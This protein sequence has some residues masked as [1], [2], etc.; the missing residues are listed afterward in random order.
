MIIRYKN[1]RGAVTVEAIISLTTFMFAIVTVFT[2]VNICIVQSQISYALNVTAK[3]ISQYSY[4][5]S[6]SG[7][8]DSFKSVHENGE[9][10]TKDIDVF[11]SDITAAYE[12]MEQL[13]REA[14]NAKDAGNV[15]DIKSAWNNFEKNFNDLQAN[16][17][18]IKEDISNI[19]DDPKKIIFGIAKLG[20]VKG[21]DILIS[22]CIAQ[23]LIKGMIKKNLMDE[24]NG[25][26]EVYLKNL[27]VIPDGKGSYF[28]GLDFKGS[29]IFPKGTNVIKLN[30]SY[31]VKVIALLPIKTTFRFNQTA[32]THGWPAGKFQSYEENAD[33]I[34]DEIEKK[35]K[36]N[37]SLWTN[38]TVNERSSLI[39]ELVTMDK[40]DEGYK[41]VS[42]LTDVN[43]YNEE[44][45]EFVLIVT[46]NPLWTEDG[47]AKVANDLDKEDLK[48]DI[49]NMCAKIKS[50]T[51]G[52][53]KVTVK[54]DGE[55]SDKDCTNAN[56]KIILVIPEDV[57]LKEKY[58]EAIREAETMGVEI[59]VQP[60]FGKG[61]I[62]TEKKDD[63]GE[64][65]A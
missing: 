32:I 36:E 44:N 20:V 17:G 5:Y 46:R 16:A 58:E 54:E 47:S 35:Y 25:N 23:P 63:A 3:E 56:N 64:E 38:G 12:N 14:F 22:E 19:A 26:V 21:S 15:D 7:I 62:K 11:I 45:N 24:E 2:V 50:T 1:E 52:T 10:E 40:K 55:K 31:K 33:K 39:R 59:E 28:D 42:G 18:A 13:G 57:G 43:L 65:G 53:K 48:K 6:L 29:Y 30:V 51:D 37:D 34:K 49:K 8:P 27:H 41:T 61:A 60:S 9:E 4:L